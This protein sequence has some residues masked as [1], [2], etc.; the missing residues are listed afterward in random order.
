[1][2]TDQQKNIIIEVLQSFSPKSIG[3]FGSYARNE[4]NKKS[5]LDI[6]VERISNRRI[7]P[8]S[9]EIY[10]L[11]SRPPKV[12][13]KCDVSGED[14]IHRKDD[15]E[16]TVRN[17]NR[18]DYSKEQI[19]TWPG[20]SDNYSNLGKSLLNNNSYVAIIDDKIVGF[21]DISNGGQKPF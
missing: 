16:E 13:G 10:N 18:K 15:N 2:I 4:N 5:D 11:L 1:M 14:L 21:G 8:K 9:G 7:A 20:I 12:A 19:E 3:I 6:L 17:I